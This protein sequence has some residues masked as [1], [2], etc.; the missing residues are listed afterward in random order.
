KGMDNAKADL[1]EN[2]TCILTPTT[3]DVSEASNSLRAFWQAIGMHVTEMAPDKH[4]EVVALISHLPHLLASTLC[5]Y[6]A[7][8]P[9]ALSELSGPGLKDTT[10]VAAGD[11]DMWQQILQQNSEAILSAIEGYEVAL[12]AFKATLKQSDYDNT[13]RLL[14]LGKK[15]RDGLN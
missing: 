6:L 8:Q 10:R 2:A 11:P 15:Y 7:N 3:S 5:S 4:D 13:K 1:F 14:R 12:Q 9:P